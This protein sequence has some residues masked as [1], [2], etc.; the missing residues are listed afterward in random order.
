M[1]NSK[2]QFIHPNGHLGV[3]YF[4]EEDP[5]MASTTPSNAT[6]YK[7]AYGSTTTESTRLAPSP[8]KNDKGDELSF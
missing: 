3:S 8:A 5:K 7:H 1:G 4:I 6:R 2:P